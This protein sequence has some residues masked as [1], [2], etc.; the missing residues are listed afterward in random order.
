MSDVEEIIRESIQDR[1]GLG[2]LMRFNALRAGNF[3]T[4]DGRP[5]LA[6]IG[7]AV[8]GTFPADQA[9]AIM[10]VVARRLEEDDWPEKQRHPVSNNPEAPEVPAAFA[11]YFN[12]EPGH[13]RDIVNEARR[14][15]VA[16]GKAMPST[17]APH[18]DRVIVAQHEQVPAG[19]QP[20]EKVT[21][22]G[23]VSAGKTK[24]GDAAT[25]QPE[26]R[27]EPASPHA[28]P[29]PDLDREV[30][31]FVYSRKYCTSIDI[32]DFIRCLKDKG[33]SLQE[34]SV[35]EKIYVTIEE[36][37]K[38]ARFAI[39]KE[40]EGLID[41][42]QAPEEPEIQGLIRRLGEAGLVFEEEDVRRMI[43][44]AVLRWYSCSAGNRRSLSLSSGS[45]GKERNG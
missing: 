41:A 36:R 39:E 12:T 21:E 15:R 4:A 44:G 45:V 5:D 34:Y 14:M 11:N 27:Q 20:A 1:C 33:Y 8:S 35:L 9:S 30:R 43:R 37:K 23:D 19:A 24:N 3:E 22:I 13:I 31:D 28:A 18:A 2:G 38:E 40:I 16:M 25:P 17:Q 26:A 7:A 29:E 6:G 32:M 42:T 10:A